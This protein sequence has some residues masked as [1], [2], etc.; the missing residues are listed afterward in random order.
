MGR[1]DSME[2]PSADNENSACIGQEKTPEVIVVQTD[3]V[4]SPEADQVYG[5]RW[6]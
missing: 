6:E 3:T 5:R 1:K 4:S 2:E